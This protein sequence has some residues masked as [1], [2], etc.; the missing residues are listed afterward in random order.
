MRGVVLIEGPPPLSRSALTLE[1]STYLRSTQLTP[2]CDGVVLIEVT[3]LCLG[4]GI[5]LRI[6]SIFEI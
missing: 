3:L 1:V 6:I 5:G 2:T 4:V